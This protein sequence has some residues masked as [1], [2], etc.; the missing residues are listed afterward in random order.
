M[1]KLDQKKL[2]LDSYN[3]QNWLT[4]QTYLKHR[5]KQVWHVN[6]LKF[7]PVLSLKPKISQGISSE[8]PFI[9]H[10]CALLSGILTS[11]RHVIKTRNG[12]M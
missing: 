12:E 5:V 3:K 11:C 4:S 9:K 8:K 7:S 6:F 1:E 2:T 10:K